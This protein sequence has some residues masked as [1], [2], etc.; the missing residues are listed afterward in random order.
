[1]A[2]NRE[3]GEKALNTNSQTKP[4]I[5]D[6]SGR[7]DPEFEMPDVE[8]VERDIEQAQR[9]FGDKRPLPKPDKAA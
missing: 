9:I 1:M 2:N 8:Q 7:R 3:T 5:V 4:D 6:Q